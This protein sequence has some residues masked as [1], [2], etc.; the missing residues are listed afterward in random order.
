MIERVWDIVNTVEE[1]LK[2]DS[3]NAYAS[4]KPEIVLK[5][6]LLL[7]LNHFNPHD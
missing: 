5:A 6:W 2:L 3:I 4:P 7:L 1:Q